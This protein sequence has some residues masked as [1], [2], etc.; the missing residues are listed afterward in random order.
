MPKEEEEVEEKE[1]G[2]PS[3][4]TVTN[5]IVMDSRGMVHWK[6]LVS[7]MQLCV[8]MQVFQDQNGFLSVIPHIFRRDL[9]CEI[10]VKAH[11]NRI[12]W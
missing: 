8:Q 6:T 12:I 10:L 7:P 1:L 11:S 5:L 4:P 3:L 9:I 2:L